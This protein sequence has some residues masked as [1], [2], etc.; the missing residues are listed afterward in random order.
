MAT[1]M[2][3]SS[4]KSYATVFLNIPAVVPGVTG[5]DSYLDVPFL[6]NLMLLSP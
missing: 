5:A 6:T 4:L 2:A 1:L 3:L